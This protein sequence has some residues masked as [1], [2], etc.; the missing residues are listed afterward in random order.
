MQPFSRAPATVIMAFSHKSF[1]DS[2]MPGTCCD[3]A[4]R[5]RG[6]GSQ[7]QNRSRDL[8]IVCG[9]LAD[10]LESEEDREGLRGCLRAIMERPYQLRTSENALRLAYHW[11]DHLYRRGG[12]RCRRQGHDPGRSHGETSYLPR[13]SF[14][15]RNSAGKA[16]KGAWL[17]KA[18]FSGAVLD[19]IN[20]EE[21]VLWWAVFSWGK[22]GRLSLE[23]SGMSACGLSNAVLRKA[24][25]RRG[26]F[27][28]ANFSGADLTAAIFSLA[29]CQGASFQRAN[30]HAARFARASLEELPGMRP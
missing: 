24:D 28:E 10:L 18:D 14:R 7:P 15:E 16:S 11:S 17:Q 19:G 13:L 3:L 25:A 9:F 22:S 12:Q 6:A 23:W 26:D 8:G 1:R 29:R 5:S 27:S 2:S 4:K 20:F 21:A 30:C